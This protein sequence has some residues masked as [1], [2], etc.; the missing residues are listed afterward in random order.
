MGKKSLTKSTTKK[1][2]SAAAKKKSSKSKNTAASAKQTKKKKPTLKTL[3]KKQFDAWAPGNLFVPEPNPELE[4]AYT[5][6]PVTDDY[7]KDQA[8]SISA[9]LL[10]NFEQG[11]KKT[12]HEKPEAGKKS[13]GKTEPAKTEK[14]KKTAPKQKGKKQG[15]KSEPKA[16]KTENQAKKAEAKPK[17]AKK[18]VTV[19]ELLAIKFDSWKPEK[20]YLPP[21]DTAR[22]KDFTAPPVTD[23]Y[24][25]DGT[26]KIRG[27]LKQQFDIASPEFQKPPEPPKPPVTPKKRFPLEPGQ[28]I[29]IIAALTVV[30]LLVCTSL[31]NVNNYY[32][33][34]TKTGLEIWQGKFSPKGEDK[35]VTLPGH[36]APESLKETYSR[37]E[38]MQVAFDY[39]INKAELLSESGSL[40][41]LQSIKDNLSKAKKYAV[42]KEQKQL[43]SQ[44]IERIDFIML[45][46]K[47]DL[48][49]EKNTIESLESALEYLDQALK[50][51]IDKQS[52]QTV[53]KRMEQFRQR[54]KALEPVEKTVVKPEPKKESAGE[55]SQQKQTATDAKDPKT[56]DAKIDDTKK[57]AEDKN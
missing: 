46:F 38:A 41:D 1:K 19:K 24:D 44:R 49:A 28:L 34:E 15:Q 4:N 23:D 12:T 32:L 56:E 31:S 22:G 47:A 50:L 11:D 26:E 25:K 3:R 10:K 35:I 40:P 54:K 33:K 43:V 8:E 16:D 52:V 53:E 36:K 13:P 17:P 7:S 2:S 14:S 27:L 20:P 57:K 39:Y 45:L 21:D 51:N 48:A 42:T 5:A 37:N 18:Q 30:V 9:L 6:P 29:L 55:Q